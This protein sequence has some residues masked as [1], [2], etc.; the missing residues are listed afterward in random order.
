MKLSSRERFLG[1]LVA[2]SAF[3]ILNLFLLSALGKRNTALRVDLA[4][5]Q[6]ELGTIRDTLA[7]R[8]Q[9]AAREAAITTKQP[10][11]S[12][13]NAAGVELLD[14]VHDI[15][16]KNQIT[17][18][19]EVLGGGVKNLWYRSVPVSLDVH[20]SWPGLI[21]F[22]YALQRPDQFIVCESANIQVDP[23]DPTK[24]LAHFKIA[25]WYAP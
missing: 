9:W 23:S 20:S 10:R 5:R 17:T 18:E 3:V 13:E 16:K 1:L 8:D 25:R 11:L 22:L 2:G 4:Q 24:M 19:N 6:L 7:Q 12:N 15:A 14:V 21:S